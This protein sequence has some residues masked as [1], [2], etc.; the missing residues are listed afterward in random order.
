MHTAKSLT[1]KQLA[2]LNAAARRQAI[3]DL[4]PTDKAVRALADQ[5]VFEILD[6]RDMREQGRVADILMR[7]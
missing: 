3:K 7:D 1:K 6:S 2:R 5:H 4:A